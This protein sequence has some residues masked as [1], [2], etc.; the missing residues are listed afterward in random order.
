VLNMFSVL[1]RVGFIAVAVISIGASSQSGV[2]GQAPNDCPSDTQSEVTLPEGKGALIQAVRFRAEVSYFWVQYNRGDK[3]LADGPPLTSIDPE[4]KQTFF[5][6]IT[7]TTPGPIVYT[8]RTPGSLDPVPGG[9]LKVRI[10][11]RWAIRDKRDQ[12][13]RLNVVPTATQTALQYFTGNNEPWNQQ[14]AIIYR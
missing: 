8:A 5:Q 11:A 12:C 3:W 14:V 2:V 1:V 13:M 10:Q 7:G 6:R 4:V 9:R